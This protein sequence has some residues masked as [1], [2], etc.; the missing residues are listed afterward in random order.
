MLGSHNRTMMTQEKIS[1]IKTLSPVLNL[2]QKAD[3]PLIINFIG[4]HLLPT[5]MSFVFIKINKY[6]PI[7]QITRRIISYC[8]Q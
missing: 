3:L 1:K 2:I 8:Q 7:Y 6:I 4:S 5:V